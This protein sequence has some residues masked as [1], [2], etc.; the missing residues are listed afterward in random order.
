LRTRWAI[1]CTG[2]PSRALRPAHERELSANRFAG[3]SLER[4]GIPDRTE[5]TAYYQLT[6]DDFTGG[7]GSQRS[8]A[9]RVAAFEDGWQRAALGLREQH[10]EPAGALGED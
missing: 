5:V 9:E 2:I 10:V 3:Y 7:D 1:N 8:G 4:L 6:G